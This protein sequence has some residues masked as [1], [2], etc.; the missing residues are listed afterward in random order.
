MRTRLRLL[1]ASLTSLVGGTPGEGRG[2]AS[3]TER[4][5]IDGRELSTEFL[6]FKLQSFSI[7]GAISC[8]VIFLTSGPRLQ[9]RC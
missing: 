6:S 2:R 4:M 3:T 8:G 7:I 5:A 1:Y 9:I